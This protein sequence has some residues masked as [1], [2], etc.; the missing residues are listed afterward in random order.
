MCFVDKS[1]VKKN[2]KV[3]ISLA[4]FEELV[5]AYT[6]LKVIK[7]CLEKMHFLSGISYDELKKINW[8]AFE[9]LPGSALEEE[10]S[11]VNVFKVKF[12]GELVK[13]G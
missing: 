13:R 11:K 7:E 2:H 3:E 1:K 6:E 5:S 9:Y 8:T 10:P 12:E 4:D